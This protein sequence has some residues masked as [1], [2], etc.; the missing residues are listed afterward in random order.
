MLI[1]IHAIDDPA[2]QRPL[3]YD[4]HKAHLARA[5]E[6]GVK[7]VIGGPLL[8]DDGQTPIGSLMVFEASDKESVARFN[9]DDP[10]RKG[11]VWR[12]V[13]LSQFDRRT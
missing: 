12:T 3:Y 7:L 5:G 11:G 9:A 13:C 6:Y 2:A 1:A 10:F 8:G 4:G